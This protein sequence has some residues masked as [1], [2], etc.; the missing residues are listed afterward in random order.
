MKENTGDVLIETLKKKKTL[1]LRVFPVFD[2]NDSH[3]GSGPVATW[4]PRSPRR[5]LLA[6]A[7]AFDNL[8]VCWETSDEVFLHGARRGE[9]A[10]RQKINIFRDSWRFGVSRNLERVARRGG[11]GA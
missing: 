3:V 8:P 10:C 6:A 2:A 4:P 11:E 7:A 9:K 1:T 5:V